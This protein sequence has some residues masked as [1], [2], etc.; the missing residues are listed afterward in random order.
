MSFFIQAQQS[1]AAHRKAVIGR[2][3]ALW[4]K[5]LD[6]A[7]GGSLGDDIDADALADALGWPACD[8]AA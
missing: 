5:C 3:V 6:N 1:L 2:L 8:R 7:L 4:A